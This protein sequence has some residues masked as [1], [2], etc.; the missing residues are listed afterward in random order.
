[1]HDRHFASPGRR[2]DVDP[3][4][5]AARA[6]AATLAEQLPPMQ[7]AP[8][9]TESDVMQWEPIDP[10]ELLSAP[11]TATDEP[12]ASAAKKKS[13]KKNRFTPYAGP[14]TKENLRS[15]RYAKGKPP[16]VVNL[17][18][19]SLGTADSRKNGADGEITIDPGTV[20]GGYV[21][22]FHKKF[23]FEKGKRKKVE[24]YDPTGWAR[25]ARLPNR[26]RAA[27]RTTQKTVRKTLAR[28]KGPG[29]AAKLARGAPKSFAPQNAELLI[30]KTPAVPFRIKGGSKTGDGTS[31][32]GYTPNPDYGTSVIV[33]T[34]NPP[35]AT[36]ANGKRYTGSGGV[37]VFIPVSSP[38]RLTEAP[39]Q[40]IQSKDKR[41]T[42]RFVYVQAKVAG[43]KTFSWVMERWEYRGPTGT[44]RGHNFT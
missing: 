4:P 43:T 28:G 44:V 39:P 34:W 14:H 1:V 7:H 11:P 2:N 16:A 27:I 13:S 9:T 33:G 17:G 8:L 12:V 35:G 10:G 31:L 26:A 6:G 25:I 30:G 19:E 38:F 3:R 24:S 29:S 36:N 40:E 22:V 42:A 20:V 41:G 5:S 21:L 37:R 32:G 18:G 15:F 23:V